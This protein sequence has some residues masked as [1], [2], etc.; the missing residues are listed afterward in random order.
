M[1]RLLKE[2]DK[3]PLLN[4][5]YQECEFNIFPIGDI[6]AFGFN[7]P[8]QTVYGEFDQEGNYISILLFY[9]ENVIYY[10]HLESFN[11]EYLKILDKHEFHFMGGKESLLEL[12]YPHLKNFTKKSMHF[13][14]IN[15]LEKRVDT[16]QSILELSSEKDFEDLY[17]LLV[18]IE[19]FGV[20]K[21][22]KNTFVSNKLKG[23]EMSK[24]VGIYKDNILV[25]SAAT[26]A[27]TTKSAMV[28]GVASKEGYRNKGYASDLVIYLANH[29]ILDK[30]KSLS[31]FYDNPKAGS[32]YHKIG[33]IDI[34]KWM[35]LHEND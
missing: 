27:E 8:F 2:E 17:E 10:T 24:T 23:L 32:I 5:L 22:S 18:E 35:M 30:Q 33:F 26:T 31:L 15:T 11:D 13:C 16:R 29:F 19:E 20:K 12:I 7:E 34:G 25:A 6:E 4:Y 28:V 9:R 21:Q 14:S 3:T 1:I